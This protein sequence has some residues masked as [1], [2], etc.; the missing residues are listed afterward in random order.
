MNWF[1]C[2]SVVIDVYFFTVSV[3]L[4][5]AAICLYRS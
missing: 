1:P 3:V 5:K 2:L 4:M